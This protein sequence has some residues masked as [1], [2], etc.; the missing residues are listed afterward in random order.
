MLGPTFLWQG[1]IPACAGEPWPAVVTDTVYQVYPGVCGGTL[2]PVAITD[3]DTGLSPRVRGN[4]HLPRS[5]FRLSGSIPAC[6]GNHPPAVGI[7]LGMGS[8]P[9]CAGEPRRGRAVAGL[10]PVYPRVCGGTTFPPLSGAPYGVYPRVCGGTTT[11]QRGEIDGQGL[12][13]VCGGTQRP[14]FHSPF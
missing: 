6:A 2:D 7:A 9:A 3:E 11:K 12:S 5:D 13:R 4:R 8:I 14:S 1:S 10:R